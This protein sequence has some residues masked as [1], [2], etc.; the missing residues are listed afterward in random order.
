[1]KL[2][3]E[4]CARIGLRGSFGFKSVNTVL[5]LRR[6][7]WWGSSV[8][9]LC[10]GVT[11]VQRDTESVTQTKLL[12]FPVFHNPS[13]H[14]GAVPLLPPP[15]YSPFAS[16]LLWS[17]FSPERRHLNHIVP[18]SRFLFL[19]LPVCSAAP[20]RAP[21]LRLSQHVSLF[22]SLSITVVPSCPAQLDSLCRL[23]PFHS[24]FLL[25]GETFSGHSWT[26][27][28]TSRQSRCLEVTE[29]LKHCILYRKTDRRMDRE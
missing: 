28:P 2:F 24:M 18:P 1:M 9:C 7:Q 17:W 11:D 22:F 23:R 12:D 4:L 27:W 6:F 5:L 25:S 21:L 19:F 26:E 3:S 15:L 13:L 14:P 10:L 16:L 20:Q 29:L 8:G